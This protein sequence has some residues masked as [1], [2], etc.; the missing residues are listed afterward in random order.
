M[1]ICG[2]KT[3]YTIDFLIFSKYIHMGNKRSALHWKEWGKSLNQ[4]FSIVFQ[5]Q[6]G[7]PLNMAWK[8]GFFL[9]PFRH[10]LRRRKAEEVR[11]FFIKK[12]IFH[13]SILMFAK[14]AFCKYFFEFK[15][16][17]YSFDFNYKLNFQ[18]FL[19]LK[20]FQFV[21]DLVF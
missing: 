16:K 6:L 18:S 19:S 2:R 1:S 4:L 9:C 20:K 13:A 8:D 17:Y 7:F 3:S 12:A 14:N 15:E 21:T 11:A 10:I 5:L